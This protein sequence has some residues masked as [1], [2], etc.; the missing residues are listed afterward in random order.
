[1]RTGRV[2]V[3]EPRWPVET[4]GWSPLSHCEAFLLKVRLTGIV[5]SRL[6]PIRFTGSGLDLMKFI[7]KI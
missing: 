5:F 4:R 6:C 7:P 3:R 1:M 2:V